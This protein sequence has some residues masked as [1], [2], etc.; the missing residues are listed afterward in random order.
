MDQVRFDCYYLVPQFEINVISTQSAFVFPPNV[1]VVLPCQNDG[2]LCLD[3]LITSD[4]IRKYNL[5]EANQRPTRGQPC[6]RVDILLEGSY[7]R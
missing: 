7:R 4:A 6:V 3:L 2:P 5:P 1:T